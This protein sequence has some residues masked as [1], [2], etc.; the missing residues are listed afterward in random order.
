MP[1]NVNWATLRF[2]SECWWIVYD[3]DRSGEGSGVELRGRR[4][5]GGE[6]FRQVSYRDGSERKLVAG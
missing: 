2:E 3:S 1:A 6:E 4:G 5:G